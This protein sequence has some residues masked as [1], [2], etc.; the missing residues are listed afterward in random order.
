MSYVTLQYQYPKL[1][2]IQNNIKAV[3]KDKFESCF[4][5]QLMSKEKRNFYAFK[6]VPLDISTKSSTFSSKAQIT[7]L[8]PDSSIGQFLAKKFEKKLYKG[9]NNQGKGCR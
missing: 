7:I 6:R 5:F 2:T 8:L 4:Y 1:P 3:I 9:K